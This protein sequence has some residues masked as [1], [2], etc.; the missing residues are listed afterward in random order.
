MKISAEVLEGIIGRSDLNFDQ[1]GTR[2]FSTRVPASK[3]GTLSRSGSTVQIPITIADLSTGGVGILFP[4]RMNSGEKFV[5]RTTGPTGTRLCVEC[6]VRWC[7]ENA[8]GRHRVG[9][10]FLTLVEDEVEL[11]AVG[12]VDVGSS[13]VSAPLR[14]RKS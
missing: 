1:D 12:S 8:N 7:Q 4:T 14:T 2:R 5:L 11:Q 6:V 13:A 9:A 3:R 10:E